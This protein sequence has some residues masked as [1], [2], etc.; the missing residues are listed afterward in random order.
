MNTSLEN[1]KKA[2]LER[3]S[4]SRKNYRF[5]LAD[6]DEQSQRAHANVFPRSRTFRFATRHPYYISIGLLAALSL[7]PRNSL[8]R[9]VKGGAALTAGL[10]GSSARTLLMRQVLPSVARSLRSSRNRL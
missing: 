9:A 6:K 1:E 10:L 8:S 5:R 7:L 2:V 4:A 3:M